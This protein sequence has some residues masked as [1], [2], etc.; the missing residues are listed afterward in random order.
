MDER[1]IGL[2]QPP[3]RH[4]LVRRAAVR[5]SESLAVALG[6]RALYR[7]RWLSRARVGVREEAIAVRDLPRSLELFSIV[8][9]SDFHAGAFVRRGDLTQVVDVA[10]ELQAD[11][12]AVTGDFA[13]HGWRDALE[14]ADDLGRL[15]ARHGALAVFGN[16]DYRGRREG[17]IARE[18]AARGIEV[19]R[20]SARRIERDDGALAVVGVEDLEEGRAIDLAAARAL[21]READVEIVL[22][23]NPLGAAA[24]ARPRCA[25]ILSGHTHGCQ[26]DLPLLRRAGPVHP[27]ARV[28]LGPTRLIVNRGL[29]VIAVPW[30]SGAPTEIVRVVLERSAA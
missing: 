30:R 16:H 3:R 5:A 26:V 7:R 6:G 20:N 27:G 2:R 18:L 19:L 17:E 15:R 13:T 14:I 28:A 22:C 11:L 23:H 4:T 1:A 29:G 25:A 21:V 8:H 12:A 24:I 9:L 10:N